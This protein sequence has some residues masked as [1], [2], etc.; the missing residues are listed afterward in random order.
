MMNR[1]Q[2]FCSLFNQ[3]EWMKRQDGSRLFVECLQ[4]GKVS[5][6][7]E[8]R[9]QMTPQEVYEVLDEMLNAELRLLG[10]G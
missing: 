7:I 8:V 9:P 6:G 10:G 3:H 1:L 2:F 5:K 4:C